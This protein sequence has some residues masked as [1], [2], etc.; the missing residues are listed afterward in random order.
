MS[1]ENEEDSGVNVLEGVFGM[2]DFLKAGA[3]GQFRKDAVGT[4]ENKKMGLTIDTCY[5][6]DTHLYETGV[7]D[8][9]YRDDDN[10]IIVQD[11][12]DRESAEKGHDKWVSLITGKPPPDFLENIRQW[13]IPERKFERK[14]R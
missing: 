6:P 3:L 11:Y 5:T 8:P 7:Q 2:M 1:D 10:W 9:R 12:P 14:K 13:G 4:F